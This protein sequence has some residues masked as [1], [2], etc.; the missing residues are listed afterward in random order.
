[1]SDSLIVSALPKFKYHP[2]PIATGSIVKSSRECAACHLIKGWT[3]DG[4]V[5][6]E[7]LDGPILCPWCIADGTAHRL[8]GA[9]FLDPLGVG[10]YGDWDAVPQVV[11]EEICFRTPSFNGWQEER[12]YTHCKDAAEFLGVVGAAE[13]QAL[14][15]AAYAA[16]A[17]ESGFTGRELEDY[18]AILDKDSGPTAYVFQCRSCGSWGGYSDIH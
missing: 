9:E 11:V 17:L 12:W 5:Y 6:G 10:G 2:D 1:M 18:M 8:L 3:Y 4:P 7:D 14:D 13:L 16:I 15:H